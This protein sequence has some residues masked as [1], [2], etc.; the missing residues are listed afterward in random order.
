[1]RDWRLGRLGRLVMLVFVGLALATDAVVMS[2]ALYSERSDMVALAAGQRSET[3]AAVS[4]LLTS[5][6]QAG[7]GWDQA[8]LRGALS[9]A[10]SHHARLSVLRPDGT[11]VVRSEATTPL[12]AGATTEVR[13][14][15]VAGHQVGT[16]ELAF[17]AG[18][19]SQADRAFAASLTRALLFGA[20]AA[21]LA[22]VVGALLVVR[23]LMRP[24]RRL[25]AA[26]K[27]LARGDPVSPVAG[28]AP[29][30]LGELAATFDSM[31]RA[32]EAQQQIRRSMAADVAHEL[33]TPLAVLQA[34]TESIVDGLRPLT[35]ET[36]QSLHHEVLR[37]GRL[38]NDLQTLASSDAAGFELARSEVDLA[39]VA[40]DVA[41]SFSTRFEMAGISF[42]QS[43][44]PAPLWADPS[45][46]SQVVTNLL[47]NA[48]KY[49]PS[50]GTVNLAVYSRGDQGILEVSDAGPGVPPDE[51][52]LVFQR[53]YRGRAAR[54]T[55][56]A[57]IGLAVVHNLVQAHA[58]TVTVGRSRDGGARF[59]VSLPLRA[60]A[61]TDG[62]GP[63]GRDS[64]AG[65]G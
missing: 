46:L 29:G 64:L 8:D 33:R 27:A 37:L 52:G 49:T 15:T 26:A 59:V 55:Q 14:V 24:V 53:F 61:A 58:G 2:V 25:S 54:G 28:T 41:G 30:E 48:A 6:Y 39:D 31:A 20:L 42:S 10:A 23:A 9:V 60:R 40:A 38:V 21:A 1:M 56:G 62:P 65:R 63:A 50:G 22:A 34:E 51:A 57:G 4:S 5:T 13:A 45:R 7:Q 16:V 36:A 35:M 12:P 19:L 47:A 43:F 18:S 17:P 3:A 32:L 11:Y 44:E